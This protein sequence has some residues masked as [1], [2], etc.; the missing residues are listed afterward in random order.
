MLGSQEEVI[1]GLIAGHAW[2][3]M[4]RVQVEHAIIGP[5]HQVDHLRGGQQRSVVHVRVAAA[6]VRT[7]RLALLL[8]AAMLLQRRG[9]EV[10]VVFDGPQAV[11]AAERLRPEV[12]ILDIGLP[13]LNGY[14]VAKRIR[15]VCAAARTTMITRK[16]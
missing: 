6:V 16:T 15:S 3:G 14:E 9:H 4:A 12:I 1:H 10:N 8:A 11:E 7:A 5:A 2:S 13:G